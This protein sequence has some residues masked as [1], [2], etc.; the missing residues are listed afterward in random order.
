MNIHKTNEKILI[1]MHRTKISGQ[2]IANEIGISRQAWN[3]KMKNNNFSV[4]DIITVKRM[5]F[6]D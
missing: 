5:G 6:K 4:G 3:A 2:Q 1:W